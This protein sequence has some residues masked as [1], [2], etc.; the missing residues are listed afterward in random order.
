MQRNRNY[1]WN[2]FNNLTFRSNVIVSRM[3]NTP[4]SQEAIEINADI[5]SFN[6]LYGN[7]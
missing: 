2:K 3:Y 1:E 5:L 7:G 4:H 6:L